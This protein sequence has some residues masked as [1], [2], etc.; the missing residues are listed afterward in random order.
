M[1]RV[2]RQ[3]LIFI[4][5]L[6]LLLAFTKGLVNILSNPPWQTA[7]ETMFFEAAKVT[8]ESFP[9][10]LYPDENTRLQS[11]IIV[12][13]HNHS[14]FQRLNLPE[15]IPLPATF[16]RAVFLCDSPSKLGREPLFYLITGLPIRMFTTGLLE[17]LYLSR[18]ICLLFALSGLL[19]FILS[20]K[21]SLGNDSATLLTATFLMVCHPA[22]WHLAS[23]MNN[24]AIKFF[25][26]CLGIFLITH[27][28]VKKLTKSSLIILLGWL[29]TVA[30]VRWTLLPIAVGIL[31]AGY[32]SKSRTQVYNKKLLAVTGIIVACV[33]LVFIP[34]LMDRSLLIDE[35]NHA[36][37]GI[38]NLITGQINFYSIISRLAS[39][40]WTGFGWLN[41]PIPF[42]PKILATALS[43]AWSFLLVIY[44]LHG[45]SKKFRKSEPL[46]FL[47]TIPILLMSFLIL[48]RAMSLQPSIQGRYLFPILG[49]IVLGVTRSA[50]TLPWT[51]RYFLFLL[52]ICL[53]LL[54]LSS[55]ITGW[56]SYQH[57][58]YKKNNSM[59]KATSGWYPSESGAS[60][61]WMLNQAEISLPLLARCDQKLYMDIIP[62][63]ADANETK[64][65][66]VFLNNQLIGKVIIPSHET[67]LEFSI[68]SDQIK[69]GLNM[70]RLETDGGISPFDSGKSF[71]HRYITIALKQ[72]FLSD[73]DKSLKEIIHDS[74]ISGWFISDASN[75]LIRI[76]SGNSIIID[77]ILSDE[78]ILLNFSKDSYRRIWANQ[79]EK[80]RTIEE[81]VVQ[82][83]V[84]TSS[85]SKKL[86][87]SFIS[88]K[89]STAHLPGM[90]SDEYFHLV[91]IFFWICLS[92]FIT[93][94]LIVL[95]NIAEM[96]IIEE[97]YCSG[98]DESY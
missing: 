13:A 77:E 5:L 15:Q 11:E 98:P 92:L 33:F 50:L 45:F 40:F 68:A 38:I 97:K 19:L 85:F 39:T 75:A 16:N 10:T 89:N 91:L 44:I 87:N 67:R 60:H 22:F 48:V 43:I 78:H 82:N 80:E 93:I 6:F 26:I 55:N 69:S 74:S 54:D 17:G 21:N 63:S 37:S 46:W 47:I 79:T 29:I 70:L 72:L 7:D 57:V 62:Y 4:L 12:C 90:L 64:Q 88:F 36:L 42:I 83:L 73:C 56:Y 2:S 31:I 95:L 35:L 34:L 3:T 14:F 51:R 28:S 59:V 58:G 8:G 20:L 61:R 32:F 1:L 66:R 52:L 71:D 18:F 84:Y 53:V 41:I 24:E 9:D 27:P 81:S 49:L 23:S 96:K 94:L 25:Q 76:S 65:L 86:V 30:A